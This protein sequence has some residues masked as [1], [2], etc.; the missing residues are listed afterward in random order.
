M[1]GRTITKAE[2]LAIGTEL[3]TGQTRD[4]DGGD[5]ARELTALGVE[6]RAVIALPDD[7]AAVT[8]GL[9]AALE[10]VE[11]VITTGGLGPTPDDLTREA[12]AAACGEAPAEDPELLTWLE[13]LFARRGRSMAPMNRKQAWLIP[14]A[15]AL[16]NARG[17]APGWWISRPGGRLI[18]ALPGPPRE[19]AAMWRAEALPRL[20]IRGLGRDRAATTLRLTGIGESD[21]AA[22]IGEPVLRA[23]NPDVATFARDDAVD[24]RIAARAAD[25]RS[26]ADLVASSLAT[27][28]PLLAGWIFARDEEGWPEALGRRLGDRRVATVEVGTGGRLV[29]LVGAAPW[30]ARADVMPASDLPLGGLAERAREAAGADLGL[31]VRARP[32]DGDTAI[33]IAIAAPGGVTALDDVAFLGGGEGRRRSALAACA[34]LWRD[35]VDASPEAPASGRPGSPN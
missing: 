21:V 10:R 6:V 19:M 23:A 16:P 3:T 25:G 17:T 26:A 32:Q 7:L 28:E 20:R 27:L 11:L 31:A 9:R 24:V 33:E 15:E 8:D 29:A 1:D 2:L 13:G 4:T 18:V 14:S 22:L 30:L 5:L 12:I 35:L 34:A